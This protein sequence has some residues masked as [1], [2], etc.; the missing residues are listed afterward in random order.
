M[1]IPSKMNSIVIANRIRHYFPY[2]QL[3]SKLYITIQFINKTTSIYAFALATIFSNVLSDLLITVHISVLICMNLITSLI[4][5]TK[6]ARD[7]M[8]KRRI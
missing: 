8:N 5:E 2:V 3:I 4:T 7:I 1:G 6:I